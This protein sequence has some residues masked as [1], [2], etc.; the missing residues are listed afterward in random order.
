MTTIE[1][2][3]KTASESKELVSKLEA[4]KAPEEA[5]GIAK[6]EGLTDNFEVFVAEMKKLHEAVK[7]LSDDD[8]AEVAGGASKS[9]KIKAGIVT[10][11]SGVSAVSALNVVT[12]TT[13]MTVT[14]LSAAA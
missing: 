8:L 7:D 9:D 2:I 14:V 4:C 5:Y 1:F 11:V 12:L 13:A 3:G 6:A 10:A